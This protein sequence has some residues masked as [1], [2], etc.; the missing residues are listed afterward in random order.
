[1]WTFSLQDIG[2]KEEEESERAL[3]PISLLRQFL[4]FSV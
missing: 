3:I 4:L 2:A 1:M